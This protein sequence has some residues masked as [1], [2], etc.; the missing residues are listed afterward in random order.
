MFLKSILG[1]TKCLCREQI[2]LKYYEAVRLRAGRLPTYILEP[3]KPPRRKK[4]GMSERSF[5][6]Q[7]GLG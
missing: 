6:S 7:K 2:L 3:V 4:I 1:Q 5:W